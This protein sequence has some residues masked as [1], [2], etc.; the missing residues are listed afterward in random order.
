MRS[1]GLQ[2]KHGLNSRHLEALALIAAQENEKVIHFLYETPHKTKNFE[3]IKNK[4]QKMAGITEYY[5]TASKKVWAKDTKNLSWPK[6]MG[7]RILKIA[8]LAA[9][10]FQN[11][12]LSIRAASLAYT[13]LMGLVPLLAVS[14]SVLK[15]LGVH[16]KMKPLLL[17]FLSPFGTQGQVITDRIISYINHLNTSVLSSMGLILLIYSVISMV[18][19]VENALNYIWKTSKSRGFSRMFSDYLSVLLVGPVL[20]F[21]AIGVTSSFMANS[22]VQ[23]VLSL[24]IFGHALYAAGELL[25]YF[26]ASAAF[27]FIYTF[28]PSVN[29]KFKAGFGGGVIAGVLWQSVEW[30]FARFTVA[31]SSY[32]A[33]YSSFAI[34]VLFVA[35]V[36]LNWEIFLI[37]ATASFYFQNPNYPL[38]EDHLQLS[39]RLKER[40][41]L[42]IMFLAGS[43]HLYKRPHWTK[44]ALA[45]RLNLPEATISEMLSL[46]EG[47]G[48]LEVSMQG[49]Y[50]PSRALETI[51]LKEVVEAARADHDQSIPDFLQLLSQVPFSAVE[52]IMEKAEKSVT[53]N[54][55]GKT[56]KDLVLAGTPRQIPPSSPIT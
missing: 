51:T 8:A 19:K 34:A 39:G 40:L 15:A 47:K 42:T 38:F 54:L 10:G 2:I 28:L 23:R 53:E 18:Q 16:N 24:R 46:L 26:F 22:V 3:K 36:D 30:A 14:F 37:G 20:V 6:A 29:V 35:W 9:M 13:T 41:V 55:W 25:P 5:R 27:I 1:K 17:G 50:L 56:V 49:G 4:K 48:L 45:R 44:E 52:Q 32:P 33:I 21:A 43:N 12:E 31:S 7:Y 11:N